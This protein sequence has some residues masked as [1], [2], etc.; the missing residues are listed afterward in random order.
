MA[1][2][3]DPRWTSDTVHAQA[4]GHRTRHQH[5]GEVDTA[6]RSTHRLLPPAAV[7]R[8]L[9]HVVLAEEVLEALVYRAPRFPPLLEHEQD[10]RVL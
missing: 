9:R 3:P 2:S 10:D 7:T 8:T 1:A 4:V 6:R 5:A